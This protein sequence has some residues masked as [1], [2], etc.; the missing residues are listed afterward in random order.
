MHAEV[1]ELDQWTTSI[2]ERLAGELAG[3]TAHLRELTADA[4]DANE[5]HT[6]A[7]M[8]TTVRQ[9]LERVQDALKRIEQGRYGLCDRCGKPI[10]RERLELLPYARSCVS[11][12]QK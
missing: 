8:I 6:R 7:A 9:Q 2:R 10:P 11:C 12:H 4:S 3:H 1:T 5:A